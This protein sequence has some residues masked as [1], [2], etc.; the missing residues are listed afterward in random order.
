MNGEL[1]QLFNKRSTSKSPRRH[2]S[3]STTNIH[4]ATAG[5]FEEGNNNQ[6]E[7]LT[8]KEKSFSSQEDA[9]PDYEE[10]QDEPS[11]DVFQALN[12]GLFK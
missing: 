8:G 6:S 5:L 12:I 3:T 1:S 7:H 2:Q 4:K 10:D 9:D 11:P